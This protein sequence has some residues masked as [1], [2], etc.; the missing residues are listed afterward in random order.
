L[1]K[2]TNYLFDKESTFDSLFLSCLI[3]IFGL[4]FSRAILSSSVVLIALS[5]FITSINSKNANNKF[6]GL[7]ILFY[8]V[9]LVSYFWTDNLKEWQFLVFK[10]SVFLL[11]P[12]GFYFYGEIDQL[13]KNKLIFIFL[14]FSI[15]SAIINTVFS[16]TKYKE[17]SD[18]AI[19]SKSLDPLIGSNYHDVSLIYALSLVILTYHII[20]TKRGKR[21]Q[22]LYFLSYLILGIGVTLLAYRLSLFVLIAT[23]SY[24]ICFTL[25]SQKKLRFSYR[26]LL[27]IILILGVTLLVFKPLNNRIQNT[28]FDLK[29]IYLG[30]NPN[31]QSLGQRWIAIKCVT[32]IIKNNIFLGVSPADLKEEMQ[33]QYSKGAYLLIPENRIFIHNQFFYYGGSYGLIWLLLFIG[34]ILIFIHKLVRNKNSLALM[35]LFVFLFQMLFE[36]TLEMQIPSYLFLFFLLITAENKILSK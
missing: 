19:R 33:L 25:L 12:I 20:L 14:I 8:L 29:S 6:A 13:K 35:L 27:S 9:L 21:I 22:Y 16:L 11:I 36:N 24:I 7:F 17:I 34:A 5:G 31:Y 4:F 10:S 26:K 2:I 32:E 15:S 3:F 1:S 28:Y 30:A 23:L 18:L